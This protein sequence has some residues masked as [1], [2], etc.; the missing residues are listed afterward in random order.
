MASAAAAAQFAQAAGE[1]AKDTTG[2]IVDKALNG[3]CNVMPHYRGNCTKKFVIC[4]YCQL[5]FCLYHAKA[6]SK[7]GAFFA[8]FTG[9][10]HSC[11]EL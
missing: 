1:I 5:E 6:L 3:D 10:G 9:G 8:N 11:D 2:K 7:S 4:E